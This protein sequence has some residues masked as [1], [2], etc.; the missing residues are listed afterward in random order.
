MHWGRFR[1]LSYIH[2]IRAAGCLLAVLFCAAAFGQQV[3]HIQTSINNGNTRGAELAPLTFHATGTSAAVTITVDPTVRD[4]TIAGFGGSFTESMAYALSK[5][6]K[7]KRQEALAAYFGPTGAD[8]TICRTHINSCDFS[9]GFY[10][11]D[12]VANDTALNN[13]NIAPDTGDLIP[14]IKDALAIKPDLKI[15]ASPW[16]PPAWMKDNNSMAGGSLKTQCYPAWAKYFSKYLKAYQQ[17]GINMWGITIQ[18]ESEFG[19]PWGGCI[20]TPQQQRDFLKFNLGPQLQKDS[21][22]VNIMFF[23]HNK[24]NMVKW[25]DV[26][27]ADPVA[28]GMVWGEAIHWYAGDQFPNVATYHQKYPTHHLLATEQCA[29]G[30]PE[31]KNDNYNTATRYAHDIIGDLANGAEGWVDWNM[32]LN[33]QGGP[34]HLN[35][36]CEAPI[37]ANANT[38]NLEYGPSYYYMK[39]FSKYVRP[40]AVRIKATSNNSSWEPVAFI[41]PDGKIVAIV[42]CSGTEITT[43]RLIC[44]S[45]QIEFPALGYTLDNF[46]WGDP[47]NVAPEAFLIARQPAAS[48]CVLYPQLR[49]ARRAFS[50]MDRPALTILDVAGRN[51]VAGPAEDLA[52]VG[53][54]LLRSEK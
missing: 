31:A 11:Y 39:Q 15:F 34:N 8:Y 46:I 51:I 33:Q 42:H 29:T 16:S 18:N 24:D 26:F 1:D 21:W 2:N 20:Y 43:G 22:N 40:G 32:V 25:A 5:V 37:I 30:A 12:E 9:L 28:S 14:L 7:A 49:D 52:G 27:Y 23:D 47:T 41:N 6:S 13:F 3:Q 35:N 4:Q 54:Y 48:P 19:A 17:Y 45:K 44:G 50:P 38:G 36:W 10:S 53:M